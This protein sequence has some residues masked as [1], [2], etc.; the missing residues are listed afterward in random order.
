MYCKALLLAAVLALAGCKRPPEPAFERIAVPPFENLTGD[1][2]Q[3]WVG[4]ALAELAVEGM[5]GAPRSQAFRSGGIG[6]GVARRATHVLH[7]YLWRSAGGWRLEAMLEDLGKRRMVARASAAGAPEQGPAPLADQVLVALGRRGRSIQVRNPAVLKAYAEALSAADPGPVLEGVLSGAP[8]FAAPYLALLRVRLA[9]GDLAGARAVVARATQAPGLDGLDRA[10]LQLWA[11][12]L[13]GDY[14]ER[15]RRLEEL[16]RLMPADSEVFQSLA[17]LRLAQRDYAGAVR[18]YQEA[19]LRDPHNPVLLNESGYACAYA[20]DFSGAVAALQRYRNL[21]PLEA[22]PPDSLGDIYYQFGRFAEAEQHYLEA[23][24]KS[25]TFAGGASWFKAAHARLMRGDLE[26]ADELMRRYVEQRG[27]A[28]DTLSDV[29]QAQWEYLTGRAQRAF[30]RLRAWVA[31]AGRPG[32]QRALALSLLSMWSLES[33]QRGEARRYAEQALAAARTPLARLC[34][35]LAEPEASAAE[36]S[37]HAARAFSEP[38]SEGLRRMATAY[39]LLFGKRH[40]E[41]LPVLEELERLSPP[42]PGELTPVLLAWAALET[43]RDPG[44]RLA[45]WPVPEPRLLQPSDCLAF[46]R[47]IYL[48]AW[49]LERQGRPQEA[50]P[51]Y[52][53][54]LRYAGER[55]G[56]AGERQRAQ[57]LAGR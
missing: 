7:G 9:R 46:P 55:T 47:V 27:A 39:A 36:W 45:R 44:D 11:A 34:L 2:G 17:G 8:N 48:R 28:G 37:E 24:K 21:Q 50:L 25:P 15:S 23:T 42:A 6:D 54:F 22:N 12:T 4:V 1:P 30:A 10:R 40:R 52:R 31:A 14:Q 49:W 20:G 16:A 13:N 32:D 57:V 29:H 35:F 33:E 53:L 51:L 19:L 3:D 56:L 38:G 41:A 5:A 43:G 18:A 26:G